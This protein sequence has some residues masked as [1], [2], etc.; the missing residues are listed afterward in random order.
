MGRLT[1]LLTLP[2]L[3]LVG[4]LVLTVVLALG[5]AASQDARRSSGPPESSLYYPGAAILVDREQRDVQGFGNHA[6]N[7]PA[8]KI[9]KTRDSAPDVYL[10]YYDHLAALGWTYGGEN[11][12]LTSISAVSAGLSQQWY[13]R[14]QADAFQVQIDD[15]QRLAQEGINISVD[16]QW[17]VFEIS[18]WLNR[19]PC[20]GGL[21]G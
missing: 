7:Q 6:C 3:L 15:G 18:Y 20:P 9:L 5:L 12:S 17:T 21:A 4:S 8:L 2:R 10:W 19:K 14:G 11:D 13:S 1:R 16:S